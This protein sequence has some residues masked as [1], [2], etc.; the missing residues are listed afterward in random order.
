[1]PLPV[2]TDDLTLRRVLLAK[3][4]Y[5]SALS[6][7]RGASRGFRGIIAAVSLDLANETMLK[8][9]V[10]GLGR[11]EKPKDKFPVL[12]EQAR[13]IVAKEAGVPNQTPLPAETGGQRCS[14]GSQR[15]STLCAG[16]VRG[17]LERLPDAY[18]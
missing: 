5:R 3:S 8:A 18:P 1:M 6:D 7:A 2:A 4:I 16:P 14:F 11:G 17:G 13:L 12:V 9:V 10:L 15:R